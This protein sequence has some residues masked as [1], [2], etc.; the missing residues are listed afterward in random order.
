MRSD[1]EVVNEKLRLVAM[2]LIQRRGGNDG[3]EGG[4]NC[5]GMAPEKKKRRGERGV[6]WVE[7]WGAALGF[8]QFRYLALCK[9]EPVEGLGV[10]ALALAHLLKSTKAAKAC[11]WDKRGTVIPRDDSAIGT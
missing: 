1:N 10:L 11:G 2:V 7:S 3:G 9:S 4:T 6:R 8:R 5:D